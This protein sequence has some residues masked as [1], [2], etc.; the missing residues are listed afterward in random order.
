MKDLEKVLKGLKAQ[1]ARGP[2]GFSRTLFKKSVIGTNLK[3]SVL[4]MFNKLKDAGKIP[5]FMRIA[6]VTTIPKKGSKLK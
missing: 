1:K 5:N 4:M 2:E 3:E 6:T